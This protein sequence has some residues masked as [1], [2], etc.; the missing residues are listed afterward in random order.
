MIIQ[1]ATARN[2]G[3]APFCRRFAEDQSGQDLVEYALLSAII[4]LA[5][6]LVFPSLQSSMRDAYERWSA[7]AQEMAA[8]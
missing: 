7:S 1:V 3:L 2:A 5:G 4:G 6:I 8:P